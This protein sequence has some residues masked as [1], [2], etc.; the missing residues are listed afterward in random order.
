MLTGVGAIQLTSMHRN[1]VW[2]RQKQT[3]LL[4]EICRTRF[5]PAHAAI[6]RFFCRR[7][8]WPRMMPVPREDAL[9]LLAAVPQRATLLRTN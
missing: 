5:E 2:Q 1:L 9:A 3:E 6:E 7:Y 4:L 8:G